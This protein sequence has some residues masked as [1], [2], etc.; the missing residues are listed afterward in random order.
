L[1]LLARGVVALLQAL[2]LGAVARLGRCG[3]AFAYWLDARHR[4]VA[5]HNLAM[6]FP[7]K[8]ADELRALVWENFK[9]IGE[10]FACA[11]KTAALSDAER[12]SHLRIVGAE[13]L[14]LKD[15]RGQPVR[16]LIMAVGHFGN[17]ELYTGFSAAAPE[18]QGATTYRALA[19]RGL[20]ELLL[21]LRRRSGCR[22]F[23]RR[24]DAGALKEALHRGGLVLGLLAD[25]NVGRHGVRIPFLGHECYTSIAP[26]VLA[27]RYD[28]PLHTLICYR[29]APGQWVI[30]T[31][32]EIP[33]R[34]NGRPRSNEA[35]MRDVN[36]AFETAV[37]RDPANWFW[38]HNRW[39]DEKPARQRTTE[40]A[41]RRAVE[42][43]RGTQAAD[44]E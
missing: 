24:T 42:A 25:Q 26:A 7:D 4:R 41:E 19:D 14:R 38:V 30:E 9:R 40:R 8:S 32:D 23:E 43:D 17:F 18:Y 36:R 11:A 13:R 5:R 10:N 1:L 15:E 12:A 2:P 16:N 35:I 6:C 33:L 27:L 29:V 31:G 39:R 37:R 44:G 34:E 28:A 20:N 3:G 21:R 22:Y